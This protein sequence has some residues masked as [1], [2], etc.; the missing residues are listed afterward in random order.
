M[1]MLLTDPSTTPALQTLSTLSL[2]PSQSSNMTY[3]TTVPT[4]SPGPKL[5]DMK[6]FAYLTVPLLLGTIIMPLLASTLLRYVVKAY[7]RLR[8]WSL[9]AIVLL[10]L[11]GL[12]CLDTL[13][14]FLSRTLRYSL[15]AIT[16]AVVIYVISLLLDRKLT[17]GRPHS[18]WQSS[19]R[20]SFW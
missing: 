18:V 17:K 5:W 9:L 7:I 1:G 3:N 6:T 14:K 15:E 12:I 20:V 19:F 13:Q 11:L 4:P 10:L 2:V 16:G 8:P